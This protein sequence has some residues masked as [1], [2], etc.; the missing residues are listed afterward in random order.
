MSSFS[1]LRSSGPPRPVH[2]DHSPCCLVSGWPIPVVKSAYVAPQQPSPSTLLTQPPSLSLHRV[3]L[4]LRAQSAGLFHFSLCGKHFRIVLGSG[5]FTQAGAQPSHLCPVL[6]HPHGCGHRVSWD[7]R[8]GL[9][10]L[11][12]G[13]NGFLAEG[14]VFTVCSAPEVKS[15]GLF[16]ASQGHLR[17]G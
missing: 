13:R 7:E 6:G 10:G 2:S 8:N 5:G 12:Q 11:Q 14:R 4:S 15:H 17:C 16:L 1:K 9:T 3:F